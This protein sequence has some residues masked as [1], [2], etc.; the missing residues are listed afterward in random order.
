[1]PE[2]LGEFGTALGLQPNQAVDGVMRAA[3]L[4]H[5]RPVDFHVGA[6]DDLEDIAGQRRHGVILGKYTGRGG[7]IA[8]AGQQC[9]QAV[10]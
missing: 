5:G 10:G 1:M 9:Q 4:Q 6:L 3:P 7:A 8:A 2:G